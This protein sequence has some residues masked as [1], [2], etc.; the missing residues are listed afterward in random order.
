MMNWVIP[1][2]AAA[3]RPANLNLEVANQ[4][5]NL[6]T[7]N[8]ATSNLATSN[9]A[10]QSRQLGGAVE[11]LRDLAREEVEEES[12]ASDNYM[13]VHLNLPAKKEEVE[14][15]NTES[16]DT[17]QLMQV[18]LSSKHIKKYDFLNL[19]TPTMILAPHPGAG[20]REDQD[21]GEAREHSGQG[22]GQPGLPRHPRLPRHRHPQATRHRRRAPGPQHPRHQPQVPAPKVT[23]CPRR[24]RLTGDDV[25]V[26]RTIEEAEIKIAAEKVWVVM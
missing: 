18:I 7:S 4:R 14:E 1:P 13:S 25:V 16:E 24:R 15:E 17:L 9:L 21:E 23:T 5:N 26:V 8:H 6:A 10:T 12:T 2:V 22:P 11:D 20:G 19:S 3:P